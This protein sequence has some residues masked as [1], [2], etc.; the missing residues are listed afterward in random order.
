LAKR[1]T[2]ATK[3][4]AKKRG[5]HARP[6]W[7][8]RFLEELSKCGNVTASCEAVGVNRVTAYRRQE[9]NE[10]FAA[11]W[12][13]AVDKGVEG[14][15]DEAKR[16]AYK[17]VPEPV[18]FYQGEP[19]AIVQRYSDSLLMFLVKARRPEYKD[20]V[21]LEHTGSGGGPIRTEVKVELTASERI[22][23]AAEAFSAAAKAGL[24]DQF[25]K[26]A[27]DDELPD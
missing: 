10:A 22:D 21:A 7:P 1:S 16:R 11:A 18:G 14:L 17:G 8:G 19:G 25:L 3:A 27:E 2:K 26:P 9:A 15:I 24:L 23:R 12:E 6:D 20:R 5:A 13:E 4:T